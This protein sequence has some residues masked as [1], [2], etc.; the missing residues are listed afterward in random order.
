MTIIVKL[1]NDIYDYVRKNKKMPHLFTIN[2]VGYNKNHMVYRLSYAITHQN[3]DAKGFHIDNAK[4]PIGNK[5]NTKIYK[6]DYVDMA[7]RLCNYIEKHKQTPNYVTCKGKKVAIDLVIYEFAR[8]VIYYNNH[9]K[10]PKYCLFDSAHVRGTT[11]SAEL[12]AKSKKYGHATKSGCDNRGQ[13]TGYYCGCHSLQEVFRNLTNI[14]VPQST[15]ADWAGTTTAGTGHWGL[16]TAIAMF[17]KKY[18]KNLVGQWYNFSDLGWS[19]LKEIVKS[20]D[21]DFICH[22]LYRDEW[23]HY[24]VVNDIYDSTVDVQN[25][26]GSYC[27]RGCYC[28]YV[29]NRSKSEYRRYMSGISQKSILVIARR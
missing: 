14:V 27:D 29:E 15:I 18:N 20:N 11:T 26:L 17:N 28:G 12:K 16:D 24:E 1:A 8:I 3:K 13:N 7:T 5:L 6:S 23:G 4:N 19:G 22:N 9:K 25:S 10:L 2:N 21:K